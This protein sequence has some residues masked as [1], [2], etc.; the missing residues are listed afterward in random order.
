M[1]FDTAEPQMR[2]AK[3]IHDAIIKVCAST[4]AQ[5]D[6]QE[7]SLL[8]AKKPFREA[9]SF[10]WDGASVNV[11]KRNGFW[12][13]LQYDLKAISFA[14]NCRKIWHAV[15]FVHITFLKWL[16]KKSVPILH[17]LMYFRFV[18]RNLLARLLKVRLCPK[19]H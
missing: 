15:H 18:R 19:K 3:G 17:S 9:F 10:V 16:K 4:I 12:A 6:D 11:R 13:L 5:G 2:S 7:V 14:P 1:F 8:Q